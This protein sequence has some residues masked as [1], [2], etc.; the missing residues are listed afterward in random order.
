M[1]CEINTGKYMSENF[2]R[3][4][5]NLVSFLSISAQKYKY[6]FYG[7]LYINT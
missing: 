7:N 4:K 5:P 1:L 3:K 6:C 2:Y